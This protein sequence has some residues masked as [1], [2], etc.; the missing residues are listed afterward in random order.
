MDNLAVQR[1]N[2]RETTSDDRKAIFT[3]CRAAMSRGPLRKGFISELAD[4]LGFH[5]KTVSKQWN[6]MARKLATL[7]DNQDEE[8][9]HHII[10]ENAHILFGTGHSS[11][12]KGK[13]KYDRDELE[14]A[15]E[16]LPLKQR[17][18]V[19]HLGANLSMPKSTLQDYLRP[20]QPKKVETETAVLRRHSSALRPQLTDM[21]KL[22]RF[23]F[24]LE[25]VRGMNLRS[26][27]FN[28]Q[29]NKVHV[30]EKWFHLSRDGE[31][32]ILSAGEEAP[33]RTTRHKGYI[34]KVM[35]LCA[36][37]RPRWDHSTNTMWDGKLG[38]WPI[39]NFVLAQRNSVNRAAGTKEFKNKTVDREMYKQLLMD[40]VVQAIIDKWPLSEF[41][42]PNLK[43]MIQQDNAGGHCAA[44]D[45]DL[46]EYVE[47]IHL[48]HKIGFYNQPPNSPDLNVLDLGL[49]NALEHA[50][51]RNSPRTSMDIIAMVQRTYDEYDYK[52]INHLWLTL[53]SIY[54][55]VIVHHGCNHFKIPHMGKQK[56]ERE[57]RLPIA[58]KLSPEA[59]EE[60][61]AHGA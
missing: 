52:K 54:D 51:Y 6:Q 38:M 13:Y 12:R 30:D 4:E 35:F 21:N 23:H 27:T 59:I 42:D 11:R 5:R 14:A 41:Q 57:N 45:E 25:E 48:S 1:L 58:L 39:G 3:A 20:P 44:D 46:L 18:T 22:H 32:Y 16:A 2:R 31:R 9:H 49:F 29:H 28:P 37:A 47:S 33:K 26:P 24:A 15:V 50:Y 17:Q 53:Q 10:R 55:Q 19:R 56:L 7:L 36:Q 60:A 34:T 43:I 61:R 8:N 40:C